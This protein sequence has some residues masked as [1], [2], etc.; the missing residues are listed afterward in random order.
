MFAAFLLGATRLRALFSALAYATHY[1]S[2]YPDSPN[3]R[4]PCN[5]GFTC[6]IVK[7]QQFW[8]LPAST[9]AR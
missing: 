4:S 8:A 7:H 2:K 9:C 6:A 5:L 1:V 3:V